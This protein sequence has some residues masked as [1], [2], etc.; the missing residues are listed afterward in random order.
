MN[1][2]LERYKKLGE[3][4]DPKEVKLRPSLRV[5][6]LK[7]DESELIAR[8]KKKKIKLEKIPFLKHAYWYEADFSLGATPEYLQGFYY[9]QEAASQLPAIALDPRPTD[10]ILDSCAAPGSKTTQLA[11]LTDN[12][13]TVI[14]L[15]PNRKRLES[16]NN[17][18]E[19][20]G[21]KNTL[22]YQLDAKSCTSLNMKFDKILLDAPCSG[23]FSTDKGWFEKREVA[24]IRNNAQKQI[25]LLEASLK[26]LKPGGIIVYST[27]SLEPEEDEKVIEFALNNFPVILEDIRLKI[28]DPGTTEKTK[29]CRRLWPHKTGTQGFFIARLKKTE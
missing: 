10:T 8:L 16:L 1:I 2:F 22:T 14:A 7:I 24:G 9:L 17:N 3:E 12:K 6:T 20:S 13:G 23:N 11:Q 25:N 4:F 28:G 21:V 19:R 29:L 15:D 18:L 27:C 26:I 5:N